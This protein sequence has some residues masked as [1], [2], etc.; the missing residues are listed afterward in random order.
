MRLQRTSATIRRIVPF[1]AL[2]RSL[3]TRAP[4]AALLASIAALLL[5]P[6]AAHAHGD[7]DQSL[8]N[9]GTCEPF[10]FQTPVTQAGG[11]LQE[12]RPSQPELASVEVCL[13]SESGAIDVDVRVR[14][15]TLDAPGAVIATDS[16]VADNY[17]FAHADFGSTIAVTPDQPYVIELV[18]D[19]PV[20]W[21][22]NP[23]DMDL[24]ARGEASDAALSDFASRTY[25]A[26]PPSTPTP[27]VTNTASPTR[28]RTPSATPTRTRTPTPT[29][30]P[31]A[32]ASPSPAPSVAS[33]QPTPPPAD[34]AATRASG[35]LGGARR[36]GTIAL[37]DVGSASHDQSRS[38]APPMFVALALAGAAVLA[39]GTCLRAR[40]R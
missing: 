22:G 31:T 35:V 34:A 37:P 11:Q 30:T 8:G 13:Y 4:A 23:F 39:A 26:P 27:T 16:V 36:A 33:Q 7:L 32:A 21:L 38:P 1:N 3:A 20:S 5:S 28:T 19:S 2:R 9:D 10:R 24:Y 18:S 40:R 29:H 12:F 17:V 14:A 15:G 25:S 6:P